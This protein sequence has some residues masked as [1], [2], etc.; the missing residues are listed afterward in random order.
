VERSVI[1]QALTWYATKGGVGKSTHTANHAVMNAANGWRV[2]VVDLDS[3]GNMARLLG[4]DA[5]HGGGDDGG[6]ELFAAFNQRRR[7]RVLTNVGGRD[8]LDV[9]PGG[10]AAGELGD[11]LGF[12]AV[13]GANVVRA[14]EELLAPLAGDY[15]LVL[16]D[17]PPTWSLLHVVALATVHFVVIPA[18]PGDLQI[19]GVAHALNHVAEVQAQHNPDLAVLGVVVGKY[20]RQATRRMAEGRTELQTVLRTMEADVPIYDPWIR[21]TEAVEEMLRMG[22]VAIEHERIAEE[23]RRQRLEWLRSGRH[24]DAP[25]TLNV[26]GT[27]GLADDYSEVLATLNAAITARLGADSDVVAVAGRGR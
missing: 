17:L 23:A 27:R 26:D 9:V 14:V 19:D 12:Q 6:A 15:D 11:L 8:G 10:P 13:R 1:P 24:G 16:L 21:H 20:R 5:R 3:Q 2:L 25:P 7:P 4:Y 18:E 22:R